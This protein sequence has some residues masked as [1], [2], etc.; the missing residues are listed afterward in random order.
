MITVR[1]IQILYALAVVGIALM[2]LLIVIAAFRSSNAAGIITLILSPVIFTVLMIFARLWMEAL[3]VLSKIEE[4]TAAMAEI[5]RRE[6]PR[7]RGP[8]I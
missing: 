2:T 1:I 3:I 5:S 7:R 6:T 4:N 8:N